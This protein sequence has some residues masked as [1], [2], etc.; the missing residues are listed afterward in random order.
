MR[1]APT[2]T[3]IDT[4]TRPACPSCARTELERRPA[5]FATLRHGGSEDEADP[6][7]HLDDQRL[8]GVMESMLEEMGGM[9]ESDDPR[10]L[11]GLFR[12]FG[13]ASGLELGPKMEELM[14]QLEAG[15]DPDRLEQEMDG[16]FE[17]DE[18][19]EEFFRLKRQGWR[20][21]RRPKVDE[22]LYFL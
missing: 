22:T 16:E 5:R 1:A 12:R 21:S 9:E 14:S 13:E 8:D 6:F 10:K 19:I 7:S 3:G 17:D 2:P 20:R 4:T 18:S 11:A 15:A